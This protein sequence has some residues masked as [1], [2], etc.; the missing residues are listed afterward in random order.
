MP[1]SPPGN[2]C[3]GDKKEDGKWFQHPIYRFALPARIDKSGVASSLLA[4]ARDVAP[5]PSSRPGDGRGGRP[6]DGE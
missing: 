3:N 2:R 1:I 6:V 5:S 4:P